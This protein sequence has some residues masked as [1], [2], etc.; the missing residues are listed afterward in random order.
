MASHQ[1]G[2][3]DDGPQLYGL[4]KELHHRMMAKYS[5]QRELEAR[6]W[7]EAVLNEPIEGDFMDCLKNGVILCK[8]LNAIKPGMVKFSTSNIAFRQME[9]IGNFLTQA[10]ALGC[11]PHELFQTV[12]LYERKNPGQVVD[13]IYA[14][15]RQAHCAG[16]TGPLIGPKLAE[17]RR[18][19][20]SEQQL[21]A[22]EGIINPVQMGYNGGANL[23]GTQFGARRDPVG[24]E[25]KWER[26]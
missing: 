7:L 26:L 24:K 10:Q 2:N 11:R 22:G 1:P 19:Q 25:A 23:S 18:R 16:F 21:R 5:P 13:A 17:Q 9:N 20:F 6:S 8:T 12:D 4:D 3:E 15:S 14:L